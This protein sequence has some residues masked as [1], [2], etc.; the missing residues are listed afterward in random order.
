MLKQEKFKSFWNNKKT[1]L[2]IWLQTS[3]KTSREI[4]AVQKRTVAPN[5]RSILTFQGEMTNIEVICFKLCSI[6]IISTK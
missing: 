5:G 4:N 1:P 3:K 6:N 2:G